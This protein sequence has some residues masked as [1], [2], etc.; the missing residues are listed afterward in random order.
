[1]P[2]RR[3]SAM[4]SFLIIAALI[5]S[6]G[7]LAQ[8]T[9][10]PKVGNKPLVQI[11]PKGP[12]GCKLV[13]TVSGTKLWAGNCVANELRTAPAPTGSVPPVEEKK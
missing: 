1:M 6:T 13:G 10:A 12:T 11:K 5:F 4:K 7:A 2:V 8:T 3:G 9:A